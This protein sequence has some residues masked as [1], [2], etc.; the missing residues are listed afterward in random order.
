MFKR[1]RAGSWALGGAL[2]LS[3]CSDV[4]QDDFVYQGGNSPDPTG[5]F[6]GTVLYSGPAPSCQAYSDGSVRVVGNVVLTLFEYDNPPPPEG[7]AASSLNLLVI[8][9]DKL[10]E[11][12]D[13]ERGESLTRS[14]AFRWPR[15]PLY[16]GQEKHYQ[17]RGFF[18]RD[19][20]FIPFFSVSRLP[21]GGDV[22]GAALNS[23][24][25]ASRG[26]LRITL[27]PL[28]Q[29]EKGVVKK[30]I[31]VALGNVVRTERPAFKLDENRRL[32]AATP[33]M[34]VAAAD[35]TLTA[36]FRSL[37]CA[38]GTTAANCGMTLRRLSVEEA[39]KAESAGVKLDAGNLGAYSFYVEPV[40]I[41]TVGPGVDLNVADGKVDPHPFLGSLGLNWYTPMVLM[42]RL[43]NDIEVRTKVP[44]VVMVGSVLQDATGQPLKSSYAD[45]VPVAVAPVSAVELITGRT[46]CRVPYF[47]PGTLSL[48]TD[49]RVAQCGELPTGRFSVNVLGGLAGGT[50][51]G[52]TDPTRQESGVVFTGARYSGQSWTLPNEL[53]LAE[54]VGEPNVLVEQGAEHTFTV[55]DP[56]PDT[57]DACAATTVRGQCSDAVPYGVE[58]GR[59]DVD[60]ARCLPNDCCA[61]VAHLWEVPE[62][63]RCP[64]DPTGVTTSPS[65]I[66]HYAANGLPVPNCLPFDLPAQ[67]AP[68]PAP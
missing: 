59:F 17:V 10:F 53:A 18:D 31:T 57:A 58:D 46:D 15:L 50:E 2:L 29:A 11:P 52:A 1:L 68:A 37:T 36:S 12:A 19:N 39:Q 47:P 3:S 30:G 67:C 41:K 55:Y 54:Q 56:T 32:S 34:P 13:C 4:E 44:R 8:S 24:S 48:V 49:N 23:P 64:L 43:Q 38:A 6:E 40:D 35:S 16:L 51:A 63:R 33:F 21:T 62:P 25:D 22:I 28:E 7:S 60:T 42:T 14:V 9:G 20:D 26:F 65:S 27:P 45:N 5:I 61:A 66:H